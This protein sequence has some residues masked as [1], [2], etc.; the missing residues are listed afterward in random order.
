LI[1]FRYF[2]GPLFRKS[3]IALNQLT[4]KLTLIL[5]LTLTLTLTLSHM[6]AVK[7]DFRNSGP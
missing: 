3:A 2:E 5:T 1:L 7:T 6:T 4:L